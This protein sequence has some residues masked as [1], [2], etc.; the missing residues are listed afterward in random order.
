MTFDGAVTAPAAGFDEESESR[1]QI[2]QA[3]ALSARQRLAA[4]TD[5]YPLL[6][7]AQRRVGG[8]VV[9]EGHRPPPGR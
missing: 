8:E 6:V 5:S 1:R 3:L 9:E 2:R 7:V 4:L